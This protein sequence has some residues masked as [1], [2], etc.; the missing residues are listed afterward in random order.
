M[1]NE[2]TKLSVN[3]NKIATLRNARGKN[4]PDILHFSKIILKS[5][6]C[7]LTVHPRPDERHIRR[8][9][10]FD[11]KKLLKNY[12]DKEFNIEGYPSDS[13]IDLM[14]QI[15]PQQCT[16][17]P[18]SPKVLTSNAGWDFVKYKAFLKTR[19]QEL[20]SCQIRSSLFL[21]PLKM[22][23]NQYE[24]LQD[25]KPNRIELYTETYAEN[26]KNQDILKE[27][28]KCA[29]KVNQLNIKLN[30]GHDLN[31]KN[32]SPL[33]KAIPQI[34]EVSIG[35]ALISESL[36]EGITT[37]INKYIKIIDDCF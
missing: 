25:I 31:Q 3:I 13:F 1:K 9:D 14:K 17:V 24:S 33:L 8:A 4:T 21:E 34:K 20:Q 7:G 36:E 27:Y 5:K 6:A 12:P 15:K 32:L 35:Q 16:L 23:N 37:T 11:L 18:D 26:Y 10:V 28:K 22:N 2:K 19:V 29:N 30:A